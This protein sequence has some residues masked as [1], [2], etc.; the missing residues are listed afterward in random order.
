VV[1]NTNGGVVIEAVSEVTADGA[2]YFSA[3]GNAG[4]LDDGTS[5]V[6]EGNFA[7]GGPV[8]GAALAGRVAAGARVHR[9]VV[10]NFNVLTAVGSRNNLYWSDPLGGSSN[11]YDLFLLDSAGTTV[12]SAGVNLQTGPQDPYEEVVGGAAGNRL[13]VVRSSGASRFLHVNTNRGR[14]LIRT[15]GQTHGHSSVEDAFSVA[16]TPAGAA[17]PLAFSAGNTIE[18]FS[19]DGPR[20]VFFRADGTEFTPGDRSATGGIV[21]QKPDITAADGVSV[22]GVGGFGRPFF[23]TSAAAAHAA[24]IAALVKSANPAFTPAQIRSA[25]TSTAI[26]I[27]APGVDRDSGAGIV[28]ARA[29][30]EATG[31]IG[32]AFLQL[33]T[34]QLAE[35][36]GDRDGVVDPGEGA[37]LT[38]TLKNYG[39][40]PATGI[41]ASVTSPTSDIV[42]DS[43]N[44]RRFA[45]LVPLATGSAA[46]IRVTIGHDIGCATSGA[47][48]V[49]A[50]YGNGGPLEQRFAIP[51]G[52]RTLTFTQALDG[53][54]P[55]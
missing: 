48:I 18:T 12:L 49:R 19:S 4:N 38:L 20:R 13:V 43:P 33:E 17:F 39:V 24:A 53:S 29:A 26:D 37:G 54:T 55:P 2:L 21:R 6:W 14:L 16:A 22:S 8:V 1:S 10:Q 40:A 45:D 23:G 35:N 52:L 27:E 3:A 31:A 11:D 32:T 41:Q 50:T 30:V 42:V 7:D 44:S 28:M 36:P 15:A 25:L 5:G 51:I 47:F 46:P 34:V 9:F